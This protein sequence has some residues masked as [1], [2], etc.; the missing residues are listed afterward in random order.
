MHSVYK[1]TKGKLTK[2]VVTATVVTAIYDCYIR[3]YECLP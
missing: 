1:V 2:I 3:V